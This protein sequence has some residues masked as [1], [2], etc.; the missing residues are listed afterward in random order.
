M[1]APIYPMRA[2]VRQQRGPRLSFH[3]PPLTVRIHL[4]QSLKVAL[5]TLSTHRLILRSDLTSTL[6][7]LHN[8]H[9]PTLA[10]RP[11][12]HQAQGAMKDN[13]DR[14]GQVYHFNIHSNIT[15]HNVT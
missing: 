5:S 15:T 10:V 6:P 4:H 8:L 14:A 12:L 9:T 13:K 7:H 11:I 3:R 1:T 2:T